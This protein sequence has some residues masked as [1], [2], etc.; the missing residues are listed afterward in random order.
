MLNKNNNTK[1]D[2][3]IIDL[4]RLEGADID[5][6]SLLENGD[7]TIHGISTSGDL[8]LITEC[9]NPHNT[10]KVLYK[11]KYDCLKVIFKWWSEG[12]LSSVINAIKSMKD[13]II[14]NDFF[15]FAFLRN[16]ISNL[17]FTLELLIEI[18]I[19]AIKLSEDKYETYIKT[20]LETNYNIL[21]TFKNKTF[22]EYV[23]LYKGKSDYDEKIRKVRDLTLDIQKL[24]IIKKVKEKRY[25]EEICNIT[26]KLCIIVEEVL[27]II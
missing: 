5:F 4:N 11:K 9:S 16:D 1:P 14:M 19:M 3:T 26:M 17:P 24:E 25:N 20:G 13:K 7:K 2:N 8:L 18:I 22:K 6:D 27:S 12:N 21:K 15:I 23:A 10:V